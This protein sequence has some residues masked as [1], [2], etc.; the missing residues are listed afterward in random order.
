MSHPHALLIAAGVRE[1]TIGKLV[2]SLGSLTQIAV[3]SEAEL[4]AAGVPPKAAERL[5]A[6]FEFARASASVGWRSTMGRPEDV[7]ELLRPRIA[8]LTQEVFYVVAIDVRNGLLDAVEVA[9]GNVCGVEVHPREVFRPAIRLAAAGVI[10]AHNHPSGDPTPSPEDIALTR[11]L[12]ETGV[13]LGI[14]VMDHVVVA[15]SGFRSIAEWVGS[16]L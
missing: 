16:D 9:R 1:S 15:T 10:I 13:L 2:A 14:P 7:Y 3:A 12:R 4:R 6:A 5:C 11:R 8:H